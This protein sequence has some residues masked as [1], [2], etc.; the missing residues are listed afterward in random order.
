MPITIDGAQAVNEAKVRWAEI[1]NPLN[2]PA[3]FRL[4]P[5]SAETWWTEWD[6][7]LRTVTTLAATNSKWN[8]DQKV[9]MVVRPAGGDEQRTRESIVFK[10]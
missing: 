8:R 5:H 9:W 1:Q 7:V 10:P 2:P 3:G 4:E 6:G